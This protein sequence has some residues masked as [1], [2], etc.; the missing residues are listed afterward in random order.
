MCGCRYWGHGYLVYWPYELRVYSY[1]I[2]IILNE[3]LTTAVIMTLNL[4]GLAYICNL[5]GDGLRMLYT[6]LNPQ[7]SLFFKFSK[8][9]SEIH[10]M[11]HFS[12]CTNFRVLGLFLRWIPGAK[13]LILVLAS[14]PVYTNPFKSSSLLLTNYSLIH[15]TCILFWFSHSLRLSRSDLSSHSP[16]RNRNHKNVKLQLSERI[17]IGDMF[18]ESD[19]SHTR[20]FR[21][22]MLNLWINE[23]VLNFLKCTKLLKL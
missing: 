15:L 11:D 6:A 17:R 22:S 2:S 21:R 7:L 20:H 1:P 3:F 12:A 14:F 19:C 4:I 5:H 10:Q 16:T 18:C 8:W 13:N 23:Q 9:E